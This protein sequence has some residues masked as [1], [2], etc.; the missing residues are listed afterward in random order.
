MKIHNCINAIYKENLECNQQFHMVRS[1][2]IYFSYILIYFNL[3]DREIFI[4]HDFPR[5]IT[6]VIQFVFSPYVA[7]YVK[8]D[9]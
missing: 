5:L 4:V 1:N 2:L 6:I 8:L 3:F 9:D 7:P